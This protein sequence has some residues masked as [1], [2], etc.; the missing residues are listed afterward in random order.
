MEK[1]CKINMNSSYGSDGMNTEKYSNMKIM[2][3][4]K[5]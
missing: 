3:K 2:N 1:Y 5:A 4:N